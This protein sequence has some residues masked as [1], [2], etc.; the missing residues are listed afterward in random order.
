MQATIWLLQNPLAIHTHSRVAVSYAAARSHSYTHRKWDAD[1]GMRRGTWA[2]STSEHAHAA[3]KNNNGT[4]DFSSDKLAARTQAHDT[5]MNT[6]VTV[7]REMCLWTPSLSLLARY[8]RKHLLCGEH[9]RTKIAA[10][11]F[12]ACVADRQTVKT[13]FFKI[14]KK[15][16][17]P[18]PVQSPTIRCSVCFRHIFSFA[19][20]V[21][22]TQRMSGFLVKF[23]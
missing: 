17:S 8:E 16:K 14:K 7:N 12:D 4:A 6:A 20:S 15:S 2:A 1:D 5:A 11:R 3:C 9:R 10:H 13:L 18:A 22:I 19:F 23:W 21:Q